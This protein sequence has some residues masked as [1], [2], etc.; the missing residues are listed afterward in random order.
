M[1]LRKY[2]ILTKKIEFDDYMMHIRVASRFALTLLF[3]IF[4]TLSGAS[5]PGYKIERSYFHDGQNQASVDAVSQAEFMPFSGDLRLGLKQGATWIRFNI[6]HDDPTGN[7]AVA[8][9]GNPFILRVGPYTLD[10]IDL[11]EKVDE[12]WQVRRTGDRHPRSVTR[13]PDD[14]HCFAL[15]TYGQATSTI[16]LKVQTQGMRLIETELTLEDM[17]ALS[18]AP[19][20]ARTSTALALATGLLL[21]GAL[22]FVVQRSRLLFFYCLY[23]STVVLLIYA[24]S[25]MLAQRFLGLS[26]TTLDAVG[27]LIQVGRVATMMML[28]W[29]AI[30]PYQTTLAYRTLLQALLLGCAAN[31]L[32][33]GFGFTHLGLGFNYF[34]LAVNPAVQI[35]G[36]RTSTATATLKNIIYAAY[37]CYVAALVLGSLVAFD[38]THISVLNG[39]FQNLS[40]W[41]L[42]GVV[43]GVF[44]L[45]FVNG[46]Q[47]SKKLL[48]L[49]EVQALRIESLQAKAQREILQERN[50][51]IDV[52]THE[53]KTPLGTMRFAL[54]SLRR[55]M[56]ATPDSL[57]RIKHIDA[58]VNRMNALIEHVASSIKQEDRNPTLCLEHIPVVPLISELLQDRAEVKRF[59]CHIDEGA[60]F[61]TD[62]H[63]LT[64]IL[65]N[66]LSN[67]EKYASSGDI[68]LFVRSSENLV[69]AS[70]DKQGVRPASP[71]LHLEICNRVSPE[72]APDASRLF[73]RYYRHPNVLG[74]PG[75]GIGLNLVQVAAEN[76][77]AK[78][79][80]R[81]ENG[82]AIF[83]VQVPS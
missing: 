53:L 82:W 78:V 75:I 12:L 66:L 16:Y 5:V 8:D 56:T 59:Q 69:P 3:G 1:L 60:V 71:M 7:R 44:I 20:V 26:P 31:A 63:L 17:L 68:L 73:E 61:H 57:Q 83:E 35:Y 40:D 45:A 50:T 4:S 25:G 80:Y 52:L 76:I 9:E 72:N 39:V 58:S 32:L 64:Q 54:A 51:L 62:R 27:N 41:R 37:A 10:E 46:E 24:N 79:H 42:N 29:A 33:I 67:A 55:D 34:L 15:R 38:V 11:Y 74:L 21:L 81:Y 18:V 14:V 2:F 19:R 13:C 36:A 30:S 70:Q 43:V 65:E 47:A 28:G 49:Q 6:R 48:A 77:G 22:F 23:Q